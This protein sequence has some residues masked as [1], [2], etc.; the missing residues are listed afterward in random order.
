[1]L[2]PLNEMVVAKPKI[3][4]SNKT[5]L[6]E[7]V[8]LRVSYPV[9]NIDERN[10]NNRIYRK[11]VWEKVLG[12]TDIREKTE[13]RC[14]FGHAEHPESTQ[15]NLEKTSHIIT[16]TWLDENSS[17]VYQQFDVLDTPYGR[18]I[19]TLF[20]A[21]CQVGCSTRAEGDLKEA[22]DDKGKYM[23]VIPESYS[24]VTTDFTA[25]PSTYK[26]IPEA[27]EMNMVETIQNGMNDKKMDKDYAV[28]MLE[29]MKSKRAV[30]LLES[31][32]R[33]VKEGYEEAGQKAPRPFYAAA[34]EEPTPESEKPWLEI[35]AKMG[36]FVEAINNGSTLSRSNFY[37]LEKEIERVGAEVSAKYPEHAQ[38]KID[39]YKERLA[40]IEQM[41][42]GDIRG[43][44][45]PLPKY[46]S[47]NKKTKEN[48]T[49]DT[50][51]AK[52]KVD[53]T[54]VNV[55]VKEPEL[56]VP[57][58]ELPVEP[59]VPADPVLPEEEEEVE[60]LEVDGELDMED[61]PFENRKKKSGRVVFENY[62]SLVK[63]LEKAYA[64]MGKKSKKGLREKK[65]KIKEEYAEG[66]S[67]PVIATIELDNEERDTGEIYATLEDSSYY[68]DKEKAWV[69]Y[70]KN[71]DTG[72]DLGDMGI[73]PQRSLED[74]ILAI[75]SSWGEGS[76]DL[77]FIKDINDLED[78]RRGPLPRY[79]FK[80]T[81]KNEITKLNISLAES[82]AERTKALEIL[83][84][85]NDKLTKLEENY[86]KEVESLSESKKQIKEKDEKISALETRIKA[87]EGKLSVI[88]PQLIKVEEAKKIVSAE[89]VALKEAHKK[90]LIKKYISTRLEST[91]LQISV[92]SLTLL[93]NCQSEAEADRMFSEIMRNM[94]EGILHSGN[95]GKISGQNSEDKL[96][97]TPEEDSINKKVK[98]NVRIMTKGI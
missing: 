58:V 4:E 92:G 47:G 79:E 8:L 6:P 7:G 14:L 50:D 62:Q 78:L 2:Q 67:T 25:D 3:L 93:E 10:H 33:G 97:R 74:V 28:R 31:I 59:E 60:D 69:I 86:M 70:G 87:V 94:T 88:T 5:K 51:D 11:S 73:A 38:N 37:E 61:L 27:V 57:E 26:S 12:N 76:W 16:K 20:R 81:P 77:K 85:T 89:I 83:N 41:E 23:E 55:T 68:P 54:D 40:E 30:A 15:S 52:I 49:V 66:E 1:M 56:E 75:E 48:I 36:E 53:G 22:E 96:V 35:E 90:E 95:F 29:G 65:R 42:G 98:E 44:R 64:K 34:P 21:G 82:T 39:L 9:C 71:Q 13:R 84:A 24:Y 72:E 43:D 19:E 63:F 32:K 91:G 18:I 45:G 80:F 17:Q 46:E